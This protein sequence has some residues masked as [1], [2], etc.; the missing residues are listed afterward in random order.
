[1]PK[2][3]RCLYM[4]TVLYRFYLN[5]SNNCIAKEIVDFSRYFAL[6]LLQITKTALDVLFYVRKIGCTSRYFTI[7]AIVL[8]I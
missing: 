5:P 3:C 2:T 1:M 8:H 7:P 4:Q 6:K